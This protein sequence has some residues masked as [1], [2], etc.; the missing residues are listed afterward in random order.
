MAQIALQIPPDSRH[1]GEI[2]S[3]AVAMRQTH[4][5]TQDLGVPLDPQGIVRESK[6]CLVESGLYRP[7][8]GTIV[9]EQGLLQFLRHIHARILQQ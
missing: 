1:V 4:E 5:D 8:S 2:L 3:L 6:F 9:L 7:D